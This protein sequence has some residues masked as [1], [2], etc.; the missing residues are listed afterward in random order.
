MIFNV[1][2]YPGILNWQERMWGIIKD[3]VK[4]SRGEIPTRPLSP[5]EQQK[6]DDQM[7][8][9][10]N[11]YLKGATFNIHTTHQISIAISKMQGL[12]NSIRVS[13]F[14]LSDASVIA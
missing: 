9:A 6:Y 10:R 11:F 4:K 12:T 7:F 3:F 2:A 13:R 14:V 8:D 5:E 1:P